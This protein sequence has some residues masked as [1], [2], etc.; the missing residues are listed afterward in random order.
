MTTNPVARDLNKEWIDA[1]KS[2]GAVATPFD[3]SISYNAVAVPNPTARGIQLSS[4]IESITYASPIAPEFKI[5][6]G[7][8]TT[9]LD[10]TNRDVQESDL[11]PLSST[12]TWF[13]RD[14]ERRVLPFTPHI[15]ELPFRGP[16]A[17]GQRFTFDLGPLLVGDL[18]FGTVLQVRLGHWL[19]QQAQNLLAAGKYS[20]Q[21]PETAWEYANSLGTALIQRAELEIDGDTIET[22][23]GDFANV[24]SLLFQEYNGQVANS[25][26]SLG[27]LSIARLMAET[28]PR[29]FPTEGGVL[30]CILP[31]FFMRTKY[32]DALPM[33]SIREGLV[34]VHVTLRPF[35]ECVRQLR[36]WRESCEAVP[37]GQSFVMDSTIAPTP[38]TVTAG[39]AVPEFQS[40]RLLTYGAILDGKLRQKMLRAPH[41]I[42]HREVQTFHFDE[43]LKY[44]VGSRSESDTI[45]V[46][47]PLEA[48]HPLEEIIWFVRRK[49]VAENNAWTNY[50][51]VLER[52]WDAPG[53]GARRAAAV[54][55][56]VG[57]TVQ[58]N[59]VVLCEAEE[60]Y[61][62]QLIA[63][64]HKGGAAAYNAFVYGY[65]FARQPGEHQPS[66]TLNA[67]RLN[68][69]RLTLEV[70]PP[71]GGL[72]PAWEVK[73]FCI[74]LNWMRFE[75]GIANAMFDS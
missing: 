13:A 34:R 67:S 6:R 33:T 45:R 40:V 5:P 21:D 24:V 1:I 26:D 30:N 38:Q 14:T 18:L 57:A 58:A 28:Q 8:I 7:D 42:L 59:G 71:G 10:L 16:A 75:H 20:Y 15:Q 25:Y 49:G 48:N 62:R 41:E 69:L 73:V 55:L 56:L 47:L 53:G 44:A 17:F 36:G 61:Y 60:Q 35:E 66:G 32:Q 46:Q 19:G 2:Q 31:F 74:G 3:D 43:P 39:I 52:E 65:P 37:L 54:P 29:L 23:D 4:D 9:L 70:R 27:R 72:D 68:S 63:Q 51:S 64:H 11:F 50:T 22:I 12:T